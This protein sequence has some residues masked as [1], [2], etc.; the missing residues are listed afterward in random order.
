MNQS[1]FTFIQLLDSYRIEIPMLQ[2]DYAQGRKV[3]NAPYVRK[4]FLGA[5][6][7]ILG[8]PKGTMNLDFIYGRV[9]KGNSKPLLVLVDGQQ[10]ITTLY[11]LHWY[12]SFRAAKQKESEKYLSNFTYNTRE[13]TKNFCSHLIT[14]EIKGKIDSVTT[15]LSALIEDQFWFKGEWLSDPSVTSM[16]VMLDAIHAEFN[17]TPD[18]YSRLFIDQ[19]LTFQFYDMKALNLDDDIYIKMNSRGRPL[20][21]FEQWKSKFEQHMSQIAPDLKTQFI[22]SI[23]HK[24]TD[25][26]WRYGGNKPFDDEF[27]AFFQYITELLHYKMVSAGNLSEIYV[28]DFQDPDFWKPYYYSEQTIKY[29]I[30][31]LDF[32]A[33]IPDMDAMF[34]E[35]FTPNT[36]TSGRVAYFDG[37]FNFFQSC[38]R[39]QNF[40]IKE[41]LFFSFILE[42]GLHNGPTWDEDFLYRLRVVRNLLNTIRQVKWPTY[43]T[44]LR[45]TEFHFLQDILTSIAQYKGSCLEYLEKFNTSRKFGN[46]LIPE[47]EK[48]KWIKD[49][50]EDK[51]EIFYA[52]DNPI[53]QGILSNFAM[54]N[55]AGIGA[56]CKKL[57]SLANVDENLL[58]RALITLG[59]KGS[60]MGWSS[61]GTRYF[62]GFKDYW[63]A[64]FTAE[65]ALDLDLNLLISKYAEI[66]SSEQLSPTEV[67]W[68]ICN[69][70]INTI[71]SKGKEKKWDYYFVKYPEILGTEK[72][73]IAWEQ[74]DSSFAVRRLTSKTA[75]AYH[76]NPYVSAVARLIGDEAV[77]K[78]ADCY[79]IGIEKSPLV[80]TNKMLLDCKEE[81]WELETNGQIIDAVILEKYSC[82]KVEESRWKIPNPPE[83]DRVALA[84]SFCKEIMKKTKV[85]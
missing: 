82:E 13:Y 8:D 57:Q 5:L 37:D 35:I 1:T 24:W 32:L 47:I 45:A 34:T 3:G 65:T 68:N 79:S 21:V 59:F 58:S 4:G 6:K 10:R 40:R 20:T 43:D 64:A 85:V 23:D 31:L 55:Y 19:A 17:N 12:A 72:C 73:Q 84:V 14:S 70:F 63:Y 7:K 27:M 42:Y 80:L 36:W 61:L 78:E 2:R 49:H 39:R 51:E 46:Y 62:F 52:E 71:E 76:I 30:S 29:L 60:D 16:L 18:L 75:R 11:L 9:E 50:P 69:D 15:V 53:F 48:A 41:K 67:L 66:N 77:V 26:F 81:C 25:F 44:N 74:D 33:K 54:G 56:K 83:Q 22:N 28:P 38:I